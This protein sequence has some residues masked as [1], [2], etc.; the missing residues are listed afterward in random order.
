M[1]ERR[2]YH[3]FL[4]IAFHS[5]LFASCFEL[6]SQDSNKNH[7]SVEGSVSFGEIKK[8]DILVES[9]LQDGT[10]QGYDLRIG[11]RDMDTSVYASTYNYPTFGMGFSMANFSKVKM[12]SGAGLG[13]I[14]ALY[15]FM[16]VPLMCYKNLCLSPITSIGFS[17][18]TDTYDP[19]S[20]PDKIFSSIPFM[21]YA[22]IEARLKY[23]L[24]SQWEFGLGLNAKHY[25]NGRLGIMNKGIN[26]LGWD[27][28]LRY[29]LSPDNYPSLQKTEFPFQRYF[30]YRV[31]LGAG[32]QTY[33]EDLT[34]HKKEIR[35]G[36]ERLYSKFSTTSDVS[37]RISR[38]YGC[39]IGLNLFYVPSTHSFSE[40]DKLTFGEEST[41]TLKYEPISIGISV[42][43]E[44]YY[45]NAALFGNFGYYLYRELGR[46]KDEKPFFQQAGFRYYFPQ[47]NDLFLGCSI[48]A[49]EFRKA[50][51]FEFAVG[52]RFCPKGYKHLPPLA[53]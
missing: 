49:H 25:S 3:L 9:I 4:I 19:A 31:A 48:K 11:Y 17:Y 5:I 52:K 32:V 2:Q 45:K 50:E 43:Q 6:Y 40:Y 18:N 41:S 44:L 10:Y 36:K 51:Y 23:H 47:I 24:T 53:R 29:Y 26:I 14:Y 12:H 22:G 13:N 33:L 38:M 30:Y 27:A 20:S 42:N 8:P 21:V 16:E 28:S 39:G 34:V 7:W 46:R 15:G 1:F 37:Y 35:E